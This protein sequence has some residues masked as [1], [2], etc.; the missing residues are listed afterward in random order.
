MFSPL[1]DDDLC[2]FQAVEDF[3]VEQF[4]PELAV[5][6]FA[7]AILPGTAGFDVDRL[8]SQ[9]CKPTAHDLRRHLGTVVRPD[10][11]R[12]ATRQHDVGHR[13]KHTEAVYPSRYPDRQAF[14]GKL[15]NQGHQP[16][17]SPVVSL[18]LHKVVT[19]HMIALLRS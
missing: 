13:L 14:A 11:L 10:V 5:E 17:L 6:A 9:L 8:R 18:R 3:A 4:V 15:I 7:V 12:H 19:P 16:Q 1:F 2:F